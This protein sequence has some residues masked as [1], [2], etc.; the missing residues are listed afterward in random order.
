MGRSADSN[1]NGRASYSRPGSGARATSWDQGNSVSV[2]RHGAPTVT[3]WMEG[4][5][6]DLKSEPMAGNLRRAPLA[7]MRAHL[8][9]APIT[10]LQE[11]EE[12]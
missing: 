4:R 2:H 8:A 11:A 12:G 1:S 6:H 5:D 7:V 9:A 10:A 3:T